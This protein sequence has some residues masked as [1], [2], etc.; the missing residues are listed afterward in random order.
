[1]SD[2]VSAEKEVNK[3]YVLING[4]FYNLNLYRKIEIDIAIFKD[5]KDNYTVIFSKDSCRGSDFEKCA[6]VLDSL[7]PDEKINANIH[8]RFSCINRYW[9]VEGDAE[10]FSPKEKEG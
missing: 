8:F 10:G 7:S 9:S 5:R 1:M 3:P 4:Q 6:E 2:E